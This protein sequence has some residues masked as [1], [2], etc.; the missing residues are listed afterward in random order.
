M[1]ITEQSHTN[2]YGM[3]FCI[4]S[5]TAKSNA[6]NS[7]RI[8]GFNSLLCLETLDLKPSKPYTHV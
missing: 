7:T 6:I 4:T 5:Y 2:I 8:N 3:L 1:K